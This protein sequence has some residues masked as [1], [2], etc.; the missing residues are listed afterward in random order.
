[1]HSTPKSSDPPS[2]EREVEEEEIP[3]PR[4]NP[5]EEDGPGVEEHITVI[6]R[7]ARILWLCLV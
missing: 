6:R 4:P 3:P 7:Q 2:R 1:M 5:E